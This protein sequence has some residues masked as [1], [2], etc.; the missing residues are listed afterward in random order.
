M[1]RAFHSKNTF[2]ELDGDDISKYCNNI[3]ISDNNDEVEVTGF[4]DTTKQYVS[5]YPDVSG[6]LAGNYGD[7]DG[8]AGVALQL[9]TLKASGETVPLVYGPAGNGAGK[10]QLTYDAIVMS[11][12]K[13]SSLG[14]AVTFTS[15]L[16][17]SNPAVGDFS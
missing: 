5:G 10:V 7:D 1:V 9:E 17:L 6:T 12:D 14:G 4:T 3:A 13:T 8:A 15:K 16:R 11:F 2:I